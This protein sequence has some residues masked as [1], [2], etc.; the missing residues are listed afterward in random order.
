MAHT[1]TKLLTHVVFSTKE[2]YPWL[3]D[4][5]RDRV[6]A[7]IGGITREIRG[8][9]LIVGGMPDHVHALVQLPA[10]MSIADAVRTLKANSSR[11]IHETWPQ[12]KTFAWQ[13]AYGAFT[14]SESLKAEVIEYVEHQAV[15][16][17][18]RDFRA[19][20]LSMVKKHGIQVDERFLWN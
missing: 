16:H 7:Y 15:H 20:F 14:V 2:R 13:S 12:M 19:E 5:V 18:Q 6:F 1:C 10:D 9:A 17:K 3:T 11:W 4:A 8:K